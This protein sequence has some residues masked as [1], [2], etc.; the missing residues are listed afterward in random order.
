M[1]YQFDYL[2]VYVGPD[3]PPTSDVAFIAVT[4]LPK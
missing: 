4:K 2:S 3:A 1:S